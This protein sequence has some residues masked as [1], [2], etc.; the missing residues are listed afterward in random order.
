MHSKVK[1]TWDAEDTKRKEVQKRAFSRKEMEEE[2]MKAYI[3]SDT[4]DEDEEEEEL[5]E[6][7]KM[8]TSN[9]RYPELPRSSKEQ[10]LSEQPLRRAREHSSKRAKMR[11]REMSAEFKS[12]LRGSVWKHRR[13]SH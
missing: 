9:P 12:R 3:A 10:K 8:T 1:L 6:E 2:E 5:L 4:S 11:R 7:D 13:G